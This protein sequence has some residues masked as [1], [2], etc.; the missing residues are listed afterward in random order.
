M[1]IVMQGEL[2]VMV[3]FTAGAVTQRKEVA[4]NSRVTLHARFR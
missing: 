2:R 3:T 4:V 1:F